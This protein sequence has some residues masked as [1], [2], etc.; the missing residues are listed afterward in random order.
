MKLVFR[1]TP[2]PWLQLDT[3][4]S[5]YSRFFKLLFLRRSLLFWLFRLSALFLYV[6]VSIFLTLISLTVRI[7]I[8]WGSNKKKEW[9]SR[10]VLK[11]RKTFTIFSISTLDCEVIHCQVYSLNT[12]LDEQHLRLLVGLK[13]FT[14]LT[15]V[16]WNYPFVT[17]HVKIPISFFIFSEWIELAK[18][19]IY[20]AWVHFNWRFIW[21][22]LLKTNQIHS[23]ISLEAH[24][25]VF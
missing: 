7:W 4:I 20:N 24:R 11:P 5:V 10:W 17:A 13:L 22:E 21:F 3:S 25:S 18:Y 2:V 9:I 14:V 6:Q 19:G 1:T 15:K 16:Y 12:G 23:Q 8:Y